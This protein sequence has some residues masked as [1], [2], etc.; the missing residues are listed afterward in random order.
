LVTRSGP[1]VPVT[2][3]A[4]HPD[5]ETLAAYVDRRLSEQARDTVERHVSTCED[6]RFVLADTVAVVELE[7]GTVPHW[8][9]S[10]RWPLVSGVAAGL[11]A[12]AAVVLVITYP[13][14]FGGS[15][16]TA[17]LE[18]L[19]AAYAPEPNRAVEGRLSGF[20]YAPA[21]PA[22][23]GSSETVLSPDIRIAIAR[24]E[25]VA[26][27][28]RS[29][30]ALWAL[31]VAYVASHN[32][33]G[34]IGALEDAAR[35]E[36]GNAELQS[37]LSAA[38]LARGRTRGQPNDFERGL[39]AADRALTLQPDLAEA[40]FNRALALETLQRPDASDAWRAVAARDAG[41]PWAKEAESRTASPR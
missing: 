31:G 33:D 15:G 21:P 1:A 26:N 18:E 2:W 38:Y 40:L 34:A 19:V 20:P 9:A 29:P 35:L 12:A 14:L 37:D 16:R 22:T 27:Q 4:G 30:R 8:G 11:A 3:D 32:V 10:V 23:R 36:P 17:E 13:R 6:C 39:A 5:A 25:S 7:R 41:T 28:D 24:I